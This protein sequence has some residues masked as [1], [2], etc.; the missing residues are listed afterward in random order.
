[1]SISTIKTTR[2]SDFLTISIP[3]DQM[4][5]DDVGNILAFIKSG[6]IAQK[7]KMTEAESE[8]ISEE[9]KSSWWQKNES[10]IEQMINEN[11]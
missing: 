9:I 7:S 6:I 2:T 8:E 5:P 1:M 4:K 10:R 3:I 11:G